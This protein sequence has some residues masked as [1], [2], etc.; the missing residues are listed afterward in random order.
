MPIAQ[1]LQLS[2]GRVISK[3]INIEKILPGEMYNRSVEEENIPSSG[4][5]IFLRKQFGF[6][7]VIEGNAH[8]WRKR[9][10]EW[11]K[12]NTH[13]YIYVAKRIY[14]LYFPFSVF[15]FVRYIKFFY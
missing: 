11:A 6:F 8:V 13:I 12:I 1:S 2:G 3:I 10:S 15:V 7:K 9:K 5:K 4:Q 14:F